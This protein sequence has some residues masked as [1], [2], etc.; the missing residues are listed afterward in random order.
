M[1]FDDTTVIFL[2]Y[3]FSFNFISVESIYSKCRYSDYDVVVF[4]PFGDLTNAPLLSFE[5]L[6]SVVL[7][8]QEEEAHLSPLSSFTSSL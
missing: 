7:L 2:V 6:Q 1:I 3:F 4:S 5:T 8:L